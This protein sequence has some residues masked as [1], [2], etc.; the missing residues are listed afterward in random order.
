M[1][2]DFRYQ[3]LHKLQSNHS[4]ENC[5]LHVKMIN[6]VVSF[7]QL[8]ADTFSNYSLFLVSNSLKFVWLRVDAP[9]NPNNPS[10]SKFFKTVTHSAVRS[11]HSYSI[12]YHSTKSR[13]IASRS[14]SIVTNLI[15]QLHLSPHYYSLY[16]SLRD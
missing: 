7:S 2:L 12:L 10:I 4:S 3:F 6:L 16:I 5:R 8:R 14:F 9:L 11:K 15:L 1:D 13:V